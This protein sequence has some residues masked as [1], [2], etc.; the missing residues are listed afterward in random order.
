MTAAKYLRTMD[1]DKDKPYFVRQ[2][3]NGKWLLKAFKGAMIC[4]ATPKPAE[5]RKDL[6]KCAHCP[7]HVYVSQ[8]Q[9][10]LMAVGRDGTKAPT[11]MK[12][13]KLHLSTKDKARRIYSND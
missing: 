10:I 6:G 5:P 2:R 9:I 4:L 7:D 12:C 1:W 13:R 8:G 3:I 11:H